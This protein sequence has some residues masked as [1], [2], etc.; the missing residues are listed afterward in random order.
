[1]AKRKRAKKADEVIKR[2][3]VEKSYSESVGPLIVG[4]LWGSGEVP[5]AADYSAYSKEYEQLAWVYAAVFAIAAGVAIVPWHIWEGKPGEGKPLGED[6]PAVK[7]FMN[8]NKDMSWYDLIEYTV[9]YLE[10]GGNEY[11]EIARLLKGEGV[12]GEIYPL[13]PDRIRIRPNK[14]GRGIDY[15]RFKVTPFAKEH[16]DFPPKDII[17]FLY[18]NPMD[19]WYGLSPLS[20]AAMS[21]Q[22]ERYTIAYNQGFF[23]RD[24]T[25]PGYLHTDQPLTKTQALEIGAGWRKNLSGIANKH[26][27]PVMPRGLKFTSIGINARDMQFLKQRQYNREEILSVFGVPP[28]KVGLLAEAKYCLPPSAR[29]WT[30]AGPIRIADIKPGVEVWSFVENGLHLRRVKWSGCTGNKPLLRIKTKNRTILASPN[31]PFLV[32]KN[33]NRQICKPTVEWKMASELERGSLVVQPKSLP[34]V[35]GNFAP[36]G[37]EI[38]AEMAQFLGALIGD[39]TVDFLPKKQVRLA[40]MGNAELEEYY[41]GLAKSLFK[42]LDGLAIRLNKDPS[43]RF[44][45]LSAVRQLTDWGFATRLKFDRKDKRIPGWIFGLSRSLRLAFLAGLVDTDGSIDKHGKMTI[46]SCSKELALDYR[47]LLVS[48]GIQCSNLLEYV[49][50]ASTL[51]KHLPDQNFNKTEYHFWSISCSSALCV[52]EIPFADSRYRKRVESNPHRFKPDGMT[53]TKGVGLDDTLGFYTVLSV[54]PAGES[55]VYDI[56]VE[57]GHSFVADGFVVHNSNYQLQ[58][59]AFYRDTIQPKCRKISGK[60]TKFLRQEYGDE[61]LTFAFDLSEFLTVDKDQ[62]A[63]RLLKLFSAGALTPN[64]IIERLKLGETYSEGGDDHY[65]SAAFQPVGGEAMVAGEQQEAA[66]LEEMKSEFADFKRKVSSQLDDTDAAI[67]QK[68]NRQLDDAEVTVEVEDDE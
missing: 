26:K 10:L 66:Q 50:K 34:D 59:A 19:D 5:L 9:S 47:D 45:S 7:L 60:I 12:P 4:Q 24:A 2:R 56:R 29:V 57:D 39:G 63:T 37:S 25:P 48:V 1:M 8:P 54:E 15:Y 68:V 36:D 67:E 17:H 46:G 31:H 58:E 38:S 65:V 22:S 28:V 49:V 23:Q 55:D 14:A 62:E 3:P 27:I 11:W 52:A 16:K 41:G 6:H 51:R 61:T 44:T 20:A 21:A 64:Q 53:R 43:I 40:I 33:G 30:S 32:R 35:G 18:F 42:S 13:R